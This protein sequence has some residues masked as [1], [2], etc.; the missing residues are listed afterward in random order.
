MKQNSLHKDLK[1]QIILYPEE[2]EAP[3]ELKISYHDTVGQNST[4]ALLQI[5]C[6]SKRQWKDSCGSALY[7]AGC[8]PT[9]LITDFSFIMDCFNYFEQSVKQEN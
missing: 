3:K 9:I 6:F 7:M 2:D 5:M 1:A 4:S 8:S